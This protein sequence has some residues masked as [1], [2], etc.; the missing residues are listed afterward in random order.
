MHRHWDET[1]FPLIKKIRPKHIVEIGSETGK[2]TKNILNYCE[3]NNSKLTSI[4]PNPIFNVNELKEKYGKKFE[5]FED[6][7]LRTIPFLDEFDMIL[8]DGDHNWYTVF[9]ELKSIE[10]IYKKTDNYPII[11]LHDTGWP[12]ARRDLYYDPKTI[13]QEYLLPYDELG[14]IPYEKGLFKNKGLNSV[15]LNNALYEGG[16][17]NGVLTA[18][19]DYIEES[20]LDLLFY[21]IPAFHGLGI[22]FLKNENIQK[23]VEST[24]DYPKI[25]G[26]LEKYYLK[27]ITSDLKDEQNALQ[28]Q[29][30]EKN[31]TI[32]NLETEKNTLQQQNTEK[33][34]TIKNL[35]TEKNITQSLTTK[36]NK[37][38]EDYNL[39]EKE[40]NI[41]TDE[42]A[43]IRMNITE[44]DNQIET[45]KEEIK[46]LNLIIKEKDETINSFNEK[47]L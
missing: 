10:N 27:I 6:L 12:Y 18:V 33:D 22:L 36:L 25:L 32:K 44:K 46:I 2:N 24:I 34:N 15:G 35:E 42:N 19:E 40:K 30:T 26:E 14:M 21:S 38:K 31:N 4:D 3:E 28:Q 29:N 17:K 43:F 13:P 11:I 7:S 9:H 5:F 37:L 45:L 8:I 16:D 39:K 41:L 23:I 1:I 47:N 20:H